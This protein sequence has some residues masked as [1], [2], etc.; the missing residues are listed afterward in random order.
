MDEKEDTLADTSRRS[1]LKTG[2]VIGGAL[3]LGRS[4]FAGRGVTRISSWTLVAVP[5]TQGYARSSSLISYAQDQADWIASNVGTENIA[6]VAHEGDW[7]DDG[8]DRTE[9]ERMDD[10][11]DTVDGE[12][13]YAAAIGDNDCAVGE[14]RS[15]S[16]ANYREFFGESRYREHSWFGGSAPNDLSH[17]QRFSVS[18]YDFLHIGLEWAAPGDPSDSDTPVGWAQDVLGQPR[19]ADDHHHTHSYLWDEPGEEGRTEF[20]EEGDDGNSGQKLFE[21]LVEPNPQ[22]FHDAQRQL[23]RGHRCR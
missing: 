13:P 23:P 21:K 17:Y 3:A 14:E 15:S 1:V 22:V 20:V 2:S 10:V 9:W 11:W 5:D 19:H 7:V 8:G 16:T 12:V 4:P 18:G 6:F